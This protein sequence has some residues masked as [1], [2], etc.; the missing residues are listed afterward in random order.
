LIHFRR[1]HVSIRP[2][3]A[4]GVGA[5]VYVVS[6]PAILFQPLSPI[7]RLTT[8]DETK[9]LGSVGGGVTLSLGS[10]VKIRL[11]FRDYITNFPS[12]LSVPGPRGS[13]SGILH[14]LT[15]M[16]GFAFAF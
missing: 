5:K 4:G 16:A 7:G 2:Y 1:R 12:K 8:N 14:Q 11:D 10:R 3:L 15:P 6:G 13:S 9:F